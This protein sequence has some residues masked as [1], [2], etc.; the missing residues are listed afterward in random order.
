MG[1]KN[2][3][4]E[5]TE[6]RP[7]ER[8]KLKLGGETHS[9]GGSYFYLSGAAFQQGR[10]WCGCNKVRRDLAEFSS[11]YV[12]AICSFILAKFQVSKGVHKLQLRL[13]VHFSLIFNDYRINKIQ[14]M[15]INL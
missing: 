9:P 14:I 10:Y 11:F 12:F 1:N 2:F 4:G 15:A 7:G 13:K 8:F 3:N 6:T 5:V